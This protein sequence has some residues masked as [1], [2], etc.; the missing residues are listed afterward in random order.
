MTFR[1]NDGELEHSI[2]GKNK[3]VIVSSLICYP[4]LKWKPLP[5]CIHVTLLDQVSHFNIHPHWMQ[6][7]EE[8]VE[9]N[10]KDIS[11]SQ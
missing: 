11:H 5:L 2:V 1:N 3:N 6:C 4:L 7:G 10:V 9:R 8:M